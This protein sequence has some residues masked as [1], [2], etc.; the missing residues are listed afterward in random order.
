[1]VA[2]LG[3]KQWLYRL[4]DANDDVLEILV[5]SCRN[6]NAAKWFLR[7]LRKR[8]GV[9]RV[10]VTDKLHGYGVAIRD[11]CPGV[12]YPSHRGWKN[13]SEASYRHMLLREKIM[14]RLKSPRRGQLFLSVHDQTA[15]IFRPTRYRLSA[16][17]YRHAR[18]DAFGLLDNQAIN[19]DA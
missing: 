18:A 9:P 5:Q 13:R 17:S 8:W 2:I 4:I 6:A 19:L 14:G 16:R 7:K 12:G 1:M 10:L 11:F 3:E 15:D